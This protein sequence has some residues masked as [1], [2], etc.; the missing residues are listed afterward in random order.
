MMR[1]VFRVSIIF[2]GV[3]S[4]HRMDSPGYEK[5]ADAQ[6]EFRAVN[7][8]RLETPMIERNWARV[9]SDAV[10]AVCIVEDDRAR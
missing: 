5:F 10:L 7:K 9:A 4:D 1:P 3:R 2:T 8:Q 6:V